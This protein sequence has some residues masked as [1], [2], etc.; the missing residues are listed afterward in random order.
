MGGVERPRR[1]WLAVAGLSLWLAVAGCA[2]QRAL[3]RTPG[4]DVAAEVA[5]PPELSQANPQT[6]KPPDTD[7]TPATLPPGSPCTAQTESDPPTLPSAGIQPAG[8]R[9]KPVAQPDTST[10]P[11][12]RVEPGYLPGAVAQAVGAAEIKPSRVREAWRPEHLAM[13]AGSLPVS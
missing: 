12:K 9:E 1:K 6:A 4:T 3:D 2:T 11:W 7:T 13:L 10:T 5:P 8:F